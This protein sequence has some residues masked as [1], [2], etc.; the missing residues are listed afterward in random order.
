MRSV[1]GY[2][3]RLL[4]AAFLLTIS[5]SCEENVVDPDRTT[6]ES[7][8]PT[9]WLVLQDAFNPELSPDGN[10]ILCGTDEEVKL[11]DLTTGT[12]QTVV[13]DGP[14]RDVGI[15][16]WHPDGKRIINAYFDSFLWPLVYR[17]DV[18]DLAT[19]KATATWSTPNFWDDFGMSFYAD[20]S[21]V[22]YDDTSA[23]SVWALNIETGQTRL[24]LDGLDA[25]VSPDGNW[26]AY[27]NNLDDRELIIASMTGGVA[28]TV[29]TVGGF[30]VWTTEGDRLI[31]AEESLHQMVVID[32]A[33]LER[34]TL[35]SSTTKLF[36]PGSVQDSTLAYTMCETEQGPCGVWVTRI[37]AAI[38]LP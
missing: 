20:S 15:A 22:L 5:A 4:A 35:M 9:A 26:L 37:S 18:I 17:M 30:L 36:L 6:G 29:G 23:D 28:D 38:S 16:I 33:T 1:A 8:L 34:D 25:T 13:S 3:F 14:G 27:L 11:V 21:E 7:S 12:L 19:G 31:Y 32:R 10:S 24:F 2:S